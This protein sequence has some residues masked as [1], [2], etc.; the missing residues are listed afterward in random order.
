MAQVKA[1]DLVQTSTVIP[2]TKRLQA[3]FRAAAATGAACEVAHCRIQS[4][5][6]D[7]RDRGRQ[8]QKMGI[9]LP[10]GCAG[11]QFL[12]GVEPEGDELV[13]SKTA[14]NVFVSTNIH[15][16][17]GNMGVSD[18]VMVGVLTDECLGSAAKVA[19]DL[20]YSVT[21]VSDAT[22]AVL[23]EATEAA[24]LTLSRFGE[25]VCTDEY[26]GVVTADANAPSSRL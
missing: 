22:A 4:L 25:V 11:A 26:L 18:I 2:N 7:G 8:H 21:V 5:T 9:N 12:S 17:L 15:F 3:A 1:F 24:L 23:P 13:W 20:G 16:V 6:A 10:P 19:S 14:S